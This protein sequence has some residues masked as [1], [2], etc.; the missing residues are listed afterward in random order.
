[1]SDEASNCHPA[2]GTAIHV[3]AALIEDANGRVLLTRRADG[4]DFAGRWEFPGGKVDPGE[5]PEVALA[6]ELDEELGIRVGHSSPLIRVPFAYPDKRIVLDV[7]RLHDWQGVARGRE[8]QAL[9]WLPPDRLRSYT[10]PDA[11]LPVLA[12]LEQPAFYRVTPDLPSEACDE[13]FDERVLR[14]LSKSDALIQ[15]RLPSLDTEARAELVRRLAG[16][17]GDARSRL[18]ISADIGLARDTGIGV[19]LRASQL[20]QLSQ[21]PLPDDQRVIASCHDADEVARAAQLN[22][23]ALLVGSIHETTSHPGRP[24]IGWSRFEQLRERCPLPM[25]A[26]GGLSPADLDEARQH[27]AQ[28]VAGIRAFY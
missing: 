27:G 23:D 11:D 4:G 8:Q 13:R 21:R 7:R 2:L 6:R 15:L 25:Y 3:V 18:L 10:M 16:R 24:A 17:A 5:T 19:Q 12:V 20:R 28:G 26:I 1:M 9:A 22:V 14:H